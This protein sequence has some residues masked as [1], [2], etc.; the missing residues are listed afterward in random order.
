M[1]KIFSILVLFC[2]TGFCYSQVGINTT[3]PNAQL[4]IKSSNQASPILTDGILVPKVDVFPTGVGVNQDAMLVYLTTTIGTDLPG[5]YYYNH[6]TTSWLQIG[7]S[8]S[9]KIDDLL[10]GKSD[11]DG[12]NDGSSIFLGVG[13]GQSDDSSDNRSIGIGS[14]ALTNSVTGYANVAT[15]VNAMQSNTIG[16]YN[17][18]L[19]YATLFY[20]IDGSDN[21]AIGSGALYENLSG[22]SNIGVGINSLRL[23]TTGNQNTA[24]GSFAMYDNTIG[25][26]NLALGENALTNNI[27]GIVNTALGR[28]TLENNISGSYN[29]A[30]GWGS[31]NDNLV[32][33]NVGVGLFAM[34]Q[35]TTG[36]N[37]TALG[38][39]S[40]DNCTTGSNNTAVGK[41]ALS[42]NGDDNTSIGY[43]SM[44]H[45]TLGSEN[46]A[47]GSNALHFNNTG[48]FNVAIGSYSLH[49]N[50]IGFYN[51]GIGRHALTNITEG[52]SN[53]AVGNGAFSSATTGTRNSAF[54]SS[55]LSSNNGNQNTAIGGFSLNSNTLG[56][57]NTVIGYSAGSLNVT[58]SRNLF[59]GFQAGYNELGSNKLY[60]ENSS[61][62]ANNALIYGEFDNDLLRINGRTEITATTDASGTAGSGVLEIG[63]MLRLDGNEIITNTNSILYIQSDNNGDVEMDGGTFRLDAST[64]RI[65]IG[66]TAPGTK[67]HIVGGT[68]ASVAGG[69]YITTGNLNGQNVV[70]DEN[71]IMARNNGGISNLNLQVEGGNV[72]VGG[73]IVHTS[74]RRL[75]KNI[76]DLHYGLKELLVLQPKQ[77]NWKSRKL[78]EYKSFGLI[79]QEVQ[80]IMPELVLES[81]DEEKTLSVNYNELIPILLNAIKEQQSEIELLKIDLENYKALEAR[82]ELLEN[83]KS[84]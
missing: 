78:T 73:A 13:A 84:K 76:E 68:D 57:Y 34:S 12:T 15:G 18:A 49:E 62:N 2:F 79:A 3:T 7:N 56:E 37:N 47:V 77:Y 50:T 43:F 41:R 61:A 75:K 14:L 24:I 46:V 11:S 39:Y 64:N 25:S 42:G 6:A 44:F 31:L 83:Y 36:I 80:K 22:N 54:G 58:G 40:L 16:N 63:N 26:Y 69:G 66:V 23:N 33:E 48:N 1:K 27:D 4:D 35:N 9:E 60:I 38:S 82:I 74:D 8:G 28:A 59:L 30:V 32:S 67:L 70:I 10:D 21:I 51:I 81:E 20:N 5:F 45:N 65:G 17:T 72:T 29:V 19:G 52:N 53:V 55:A 71:E